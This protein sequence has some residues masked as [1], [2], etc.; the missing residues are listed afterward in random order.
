M[1]EE[2]KTKKEVSETDQIKSEAKTTFNDTKESFKNVKFKEDAKKTTGY[3]SGM[4][5]NPFETLKS[6]ANDSKNKNFKYALLMICVWLIAILIVEIKGSYWHK[7]F[8]GS[9]IKTIIC[10]VLAPVIGIL[11]YSLIVY[12]T[13]KDAK[14]NLTT[15][16]TVTTTALMPKILVSI[17]SILELVSSKFDE[18]VTPLYL[19]ANAVSI[20]LIYFG[21]KALIGESEEN[22]F[23][24]KY[25]LIQFVYVLVYFIFTFL[26]L[27]IPMI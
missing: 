12:F 4:L 11:A 17:I 10:S 24:K 15:N 7:G 3:V 14:K 16:I 23:F 19:F 8:V 6:I 27:A 22:E 1:A 21:T 18:I 5:K 25:C 13:Q 26:K 20:V 2:K 9:S